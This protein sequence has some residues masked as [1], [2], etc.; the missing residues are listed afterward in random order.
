MNI[1]NKYQVA[2]K[3]I[4]RQLDPNIDVKASTGVRVFGEVG[5]REL[6]ILVEVRLPRFVWKTD[7]ESSIRNWLECPRNSESF[8]VADCVR[9]KMDELHGIQCDGVVAKEIK[10]KEF[11]KKK[12]LMS[13]TQAKEYNKSNQ[14][15][16]NFLLPCPKPVFN[17]Y[18]TFESCKDHHHK[19]IRIYGIQWVC[20]PKYEIGEVLVTGLVR[21]DSYYKDISQYSRGKEC[22]YTG[23]FIDMNTTQPIYH[24][25]YRQNN[26]IDVRYRLGR[27]KYAVK[28]CLLTEV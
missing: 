11:K 8:I 9:E 26:G 25:V 20:D 24:S 6:K 12:E 7:P 2:I 28:K 10:V 1:L 15:K 16:L 3:E 14:W 13:E 17:N 21:N 19:M 5:S 27:S 18:T 23:T 22:F 4:C